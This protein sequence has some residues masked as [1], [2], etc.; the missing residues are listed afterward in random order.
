MYQP[1]SSVVLIIF[2]QLLVVLNSRSCVRTAE[3]YASWLKCFIELDPEEIVMH[4]SMVP[5]DEAREKVTIEVQP[6]YINENKDNGETDS[7][8]ASDTVAAPTSVEDEIANDGKWISTEE[9]SLV[10]HDGKSASS[11]TTTTLKVRLRV[12][13]NLQY[14]DVQ[15]VVEATT[16]KMATNADSDPSP[17]A[18]FIDLGVMCDGNRAFSRR[19]NEHVV[20]QIDDA[21]DVDDIVLVAGWASGFEAVTLTPKMVLTRKPSSTTITTTTKDDGKDQIQD[22]L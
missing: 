20:L 8:T 4:H 17:S 12:P 22:E 9:Y 13:P 3:A 1:T 16:A 6:Y 21:D 18:N 19:H 15:W 2:V 14:E 7:S 11:S 5:A 10:Q